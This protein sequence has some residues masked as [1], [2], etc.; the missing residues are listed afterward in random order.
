MMKTATILTRWLVTM[1]RGLFHKMY[2]NR[3]FVLRPNN[4]EQLAAWQYPIVAA[5][6]SVGVAEEQAQLLTPLEAN[7]TRP[8]G[9]ER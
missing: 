6:L 9:T 4:R 1:G 5:H 3:Y 7:L 8:E 2:L